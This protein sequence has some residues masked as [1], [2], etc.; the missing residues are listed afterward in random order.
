MSPWL[1]FAGIQA[2][3]IALTAVGI[4]LIAVMLALRM[5]TTRRSQYVALTAY[6]P[7][8]QAAEHVADTDIRVLRGEPLTWLW[9][10]E[11]DGLDDHGTANAFVWSAL[12]NPVS[13]LRFKTYLLGGPYWN[14]TFTVFGREFVTRIGFNTYTGFPQCSITGT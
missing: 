12:R 7:A 2:L 8:W 11:E 5:T 9:N 14:K 1:R 10:N 13:N 6:A 3:S 4:P